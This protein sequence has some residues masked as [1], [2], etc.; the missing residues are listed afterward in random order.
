MVGVDAKARS[1][2]RSAT[3]S[4]LPPACFTSRK[5]A[6]VSCIVAGHF[7]AGVSWPCVGLTGSSAAVQV[8]GAA[9]A[10]PGTVGARVAGT[11]R[12]VQAL[13]GGRSFFGPIVDIQRR[14]VGTTYN[15]FCWEFMPHQWLVQAC[16]EVWKVRG[17]GK[18]H[19]VTAVWC[20]ARHTDN[21]M[22]SLPRALATQAMEDHGG[23]AGA[24]R[25]QGAAPVLRCQERQ[26]RSS[27]PS[28]TLSCKL[29]V[30]D[31]CRSVTAA[32]SRDGRGAH[33]EGA[34]SRVCC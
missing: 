26:G 25:R 31:W 15:D 9:R 5:G 33:S 4:R 6:Y 17:T 16:L 20:H 7:P 21:L 8:H 3:S 18:Q 1:G 12:A 29:R 19:H 22:P 11:K 28:T 2:P 27:Q 10:T 32:G 34:A 30:A 13:D 14:A 23:T 24:N